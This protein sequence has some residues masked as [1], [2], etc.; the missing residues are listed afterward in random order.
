MRCRRGVRIWWV[1][2]SLVMVVVV[3]RA[4]NVSPL[5]RVTEKGCNDWIDTTACRFLRN[6][7]TY[8]CLNNMLF[9]CE[10]VEMWRHKTRRTIHFK[11]PTGC[12][13]LDISCSH[14]SSSC[15]K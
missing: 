4:P 11:K 15:S 14:Y 9:L 6:V 7:P 3:A 8:C 10:Q 2:I 13:N 5:V 1:M 12:D